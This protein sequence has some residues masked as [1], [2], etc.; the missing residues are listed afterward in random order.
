MNTYF[1]LGRYASDAVR[2]VSTD[3][4]E[5]TVHLISQLGGEIISMHAVMGGFDVILKV[6]LPDNS[7]AMKASY[8]LNILTGISFTTLPA[9]PVDDFDKIVSNQ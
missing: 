8:A 4:T 5:K 1:L 7:A 6:K 3:R 2:N 9:V